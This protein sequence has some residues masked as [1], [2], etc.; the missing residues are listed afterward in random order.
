VTSPASPSGI[1]STTVVI[2]CHR[3]RRRS[4][5]GRHRRL[6][7]TFSF[8]FLAAAMGRKSRAQEA[9]D[10][11]LE[12]AHVR[13]FF[14]AYTQTVIVVSGPARLGGVVLRHSGGTKAAQT[15]KGRAEGES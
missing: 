15:Q 2:P 13:V 7:R 9:R 8:G 1:S 12:A 10:L 6:G 11:R 5:A 4:G 14:F 3:L